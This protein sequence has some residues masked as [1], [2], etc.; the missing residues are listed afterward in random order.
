MPPTLLS[1]SSLPPIFLIGRVCHSYFKS[2][3]KLPLQ[4]MLTVGTCL[5]HFFFFL[6]LGNKQKLRTWDQRR[7]KKGKN[8]KEDRKAQLFPPITVRSLRKE[9]VE[10]ERRTKI[11]PC[12][13]QRSLTAIN[14]EHSLQL[15]K[16]SNESNA[17]NLDKQTPEPKLEQRR[18]MEMQK[19]GIAMDGRLSTSKTQRLW[20]ANWIAKLVGFD[21]TPSSS[22]IKEVVI[23]CMID[24]T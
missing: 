9:G 19:A 10:W 5:H 8:E 17:R 23:A 16:Q 15:K 7:G 11:G 18:E 24:L 20:S 22:W 6:F 1:W 2:C 3:S 13:T 14:R 21:R 4:L 12:Q